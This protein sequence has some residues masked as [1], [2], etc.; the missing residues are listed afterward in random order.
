MRGVVEF[1]RWHRICFP[2]TK[3]DCQNF[4]SSWLPDLIGQIYIDWLGPS[5][6]QGP[7]GGS[8]RSSLYPA[9]L[10]FGLDTL[11]YNIY[12]SCL[13]SWTGLVHIPLGK[14]IH[15]HHKECWYVL[16]KDVPSSC[17]PQPAQRTV[18]LVILVSFVNST[19]RAS[20]ERS[21]KFSFAAVVQ[22]IWC[23]IDSLG[24][25]KRNY[26]CL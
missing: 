18:A 15:H 10:T 25:P 22:R 7:H 16:V 9:F 2:V 17:P 14:V 11:Q 21:K 5:F 8:A 20:Q 4:S 6:G 23:A 26:S 24:S 19:T 13:S 1:L 3:F 12:S